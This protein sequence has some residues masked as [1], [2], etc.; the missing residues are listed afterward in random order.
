MHEATLRHRNLNEKKELRDSMIWSMLAEE[1]EKSPLSNIK[2]KAFN[3]V[4]NRT[5]VLT[6]VILS[7]YLL[8]DRNAST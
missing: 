7:F 4:G 1:L 6:L 5:I 2:V 8:S 3:A